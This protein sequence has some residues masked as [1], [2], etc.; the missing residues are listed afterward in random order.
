MLTD[1][2]V[3][4]DEA[5]LSGDRYIFGLAGICAEFGCGHN[6]AQK[7]KDTILKD[8]VMQAGPGCKVIIDRAMAHKLYR[9]YQMKEG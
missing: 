2:G 3:P 6:T 7:L 8:A 5:V 4:Q 1:E 9:Q